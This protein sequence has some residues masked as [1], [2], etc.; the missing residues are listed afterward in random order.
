[1]AE[2]ARHALERFLFR[3]YRFAL[4]ALPRWF[5]LEWADEM[6]TMFGERLAEAR[7]RAGS[8]AVAAAGTREIGSLGLAAFQSR[9]EQAAGR[10]HRAREAQDGSDVERT[11]PVPA[12]FYV[13]GN[14][15]Q[16]FKVAWLGALACHFA[17]F[18]VVFPELGN[19]DVRERP[20]DV[21]EIQ[22]YEPPK[23]PKESVKPREI[24]RDITPLPIPDPTP[25][26]PEPIFSEVI[27][28]RPATVMAVQ[29]EF[30]VSLPDAPPRPPQERVRAGSEVERPQLVHQAKPV[31]PELAV[32]AHLECT[33]IIEAIIGKRGD[34]I[35]AKVLRGCGLGLDESAISAVSQWRYT[36]TLVNGRPV[37][38][39]ATVT[40]IFKLIDRAP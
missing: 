27:E 17:L 2:R 26:E 15:R 22:P 7:E 31:Y 9:V 21:T 29:A 30:H 5:R 40:V 28:Y 19:T 14:D 24:R 10:V 23:P 6:R 12:F 16:R 18:M 33:V 37:E 38:V 32:R 35:D 39:V 1:M 25:D 8:I 36:P 4:G 11:D 34:V 20:R 13:D 3:L